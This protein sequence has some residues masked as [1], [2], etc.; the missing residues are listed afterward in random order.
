MTSGS[1]A[2]R[3]LIEKISADIEALDDFGKKPRD[4][5][6]GQVKRAA[7]SARET[8]SIW[9]TAINAEAA[10]ERTAARKLAFQRIGAA[11]ANVGGAAAKGAE[12][13]ATAAAAETRRMGTAARNV[14]AAPIVVGAAAAGAVGKAKDK[15]ISGLNH[16]VWVFLI[17]AMLVHIYDFASGFPRVQYGIETFSLISPQ[18]I[19]MLAALVILFSITRPRM[20]QIGAVL[21]IIILVYG[22]NALTLKDNIIHIYV[23]V[24]I[25]LWVTVFNGLS[26]DQS[27]GELMMLLFVGALAYLFPLIGYYQPALLEGSGKYFLNPLMWP[28]LFI[29]GVIRFQTESKT[30][31]AFLM[32]ILFAW[33]GLGLS[34]AWTNNEVMIGEK[35]ITRQHYITA[36]ETLKLMQEAAVK[37]VVGFVN[38]V[39]TGIS[40]QLKEQIAE[41]SGIETYGSEKQGQ[42][43]G[44]KLELSPYTSKKVDIS[45]QT[46]D[47]YATLEPIRRLEES[48]SVT[49]IKCVMES[50]DRGAKAQPKPGQTIPGQADLPIEII[51]NQQLPVTCTFPNEGIGAGS[52]TVKLSATYKF[53][54]QAE[55]RTYFMSAERLNSELQGTTLEGVANR[56]NLPTT[57]IIAKS[58]NAPVS[59]GIGGLQAKAPIG[60]SKNNKE[61]Q[62]RFIGVSLKND[63]G[64][65]RGTI[66]K[67]NSVELTVPK[68]VRLKTEDAGCYFEPS[69]EGYAV[70]QSII[71]KVKNIDED[72]YICPAEATDVTTFLNDE[73]VV[74]KAFKA[75][76]SYEYKT[77]L[78]V[79][80]EITQSTEKVAEGSTAVSGTTPITGTTSIG[81][82]KPIGKSFTHSGG[83][84]G[85]TVPCD[86]YPTDESIKVYEEMELFDRGTIKS[87]TSLKKTAEEIARKY[88]I[89]PAFV[90]ALAESESAFNTPKYSCVNSGKSSLLG[91]GWPPGCSK[92][93]ACDNEWVWSDELQVECAMQTLRNGYNGDGVYKDCVSLE[94]DK[95]W[96]CVFCHYQGAGGTSCQYNDKIRALY[97]RWS[98]YYAKQGGLS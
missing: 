81:N 60:I 13:A 48:T 35:T 79:T 83:S 9:N 51:A 7:D 38:T 74:E 97:C 24:I 34:L 70:K 67:V 5:A 95:R 21:A 65:W 88:G 57:N 71:S 87:G 58:G 94:P 1:D 39:S 80:I 93:C 89:D 69:G 49:E 19:I 30:A 4:A 91:C 6:K 50:K 85:P 10:E 72:F 66:A 78:P 27:Y 82:G 2:K 12:A 84:D 52:T 77:E 68:G 23:L 28:F 20:P 63:K 8:T 47:V 53:R 14:A 76:V 15:V 36:A 26:Q 17:I 37:G 98:A 16:N 75:T 90:P 92:T 73:I 3:Q 42:Q 62:L 96:A 56:Y 18:S 40:G 44:L 55:L 25:I 59:V 29:Y 64:T 32:I 45:Y 61:S 41:A 11:G 43:E 31:K 46:I 22:L 86:Y 54:T 33:I